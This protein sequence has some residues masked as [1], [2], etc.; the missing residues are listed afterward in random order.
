MRVYGRVYDSAGNPTW[1]TVETD[2]SGNNQYVYATALVQALRL[3]LGESP[4]YGDWGIPARNSVL[5]QIAPDYYLA[6]TQVRCAP[7]FA[8]LSITRTKA[9]T[10]PYVPSTPTYSINI[11]FTTGTK[12]Q[13][14]IDQER[15]PLPGSPPPAVPQYASG[16]S[17]QYGSGYSPTY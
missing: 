3:N 7:N 2:S 15:A 16:F 11:L 12:F 10:P 8:S 1:F 13:V 6:L 4:F 17:P 5:T 14:D 9:S